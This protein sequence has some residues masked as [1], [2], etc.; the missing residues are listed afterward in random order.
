MRRL[1]IYANIQVDLLLLQ[2]C[3][4][5]RLSIQFMDHGHDKPE[6]TAVSVDPNFAAY[7]HNDFLSLVPDRKEKPGIFLRRYLFN[8]G[9]CQKKSH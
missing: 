7:L 9:S 2:S 1:F 8:G 4:P 5:T 6:V 3:A